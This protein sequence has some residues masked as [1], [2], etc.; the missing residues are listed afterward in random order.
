MTCARSAVRKQTVTDGRCS[1][2]RPSRA[3]STCCWSATE[4]ARVQAI[5]RSRSAPARRLSVFRDIHFLAEALRV[6]R[7]PDRR[8]RHLV[9]PN[10]SG[11]R[12]GSRSA[13][14]LAHWRACGEETAPSEASAAAATRPSLPGQREA[15]GTPLRSSRR[16]ARAGRPTVWRSWP[17]GPTTSA[18][19]SS[20][21]RAQPFEDASPR[22]AWT[23]STS[24]TSPSY[25]Q[26]KLGW[27]VQGASSS[28][29]LVLLTDTGNRLA[30]GQPTLRRRLPRGR[31]VIAVPAPPGTAPAATA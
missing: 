31:Y 20:S 9:H 23:S 25:V 10:S 15:G 13:P 4:R 17:H 19:A 6:G 21:R 5:S 14:R 7:R 8:K 26:A 24:T 28:F 16:R 12:I 2:L 11:R 27:L 18:L 1:A 3:T 22:T 29:E 30:G